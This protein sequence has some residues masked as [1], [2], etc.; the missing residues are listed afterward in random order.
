LSCWR[1]HATGAGLRAEVALYRMGTIARDELGDPTQAL[2]AFE[3]LRRRYPD[4]TLRGEAELSIVGLLAR[5]GRYTEALAE[6]ATLLGQ[7]SGTERAAELHVL[8]GN[9]Y[10]EG[11][12]DLTRAASEY[13]LASVE[14]GRPATV[15]EALFL[16]A[17]TLEALG[18]QT[19]AVER[20]RQY[21]TRVHPAHEKEARKRLQR[22]SLP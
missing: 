10:R 8:R 6:S 20:Y 15:D 1:T 4:G 13:G 5:S 16:H 18:R 9:V 3:E 22:L 2:A 19:D 17:V 21:L 14:T 12:G 7:R 11:L